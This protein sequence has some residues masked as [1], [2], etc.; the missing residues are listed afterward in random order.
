MRSTYV[1]GSGFSNY[2]ARPSYQDGAVPPYIASVNGKHDGLYK[3]GERAFPDIVAR[4]YHFEIIWNGT[5]QKVDGTSCSAPAASSVISL[6][7][8]TLIAAGKPVLRFLN[9]ER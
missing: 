6:V 7:N 1:S 9:P 3:K 8:D 2:F 4:R 5:L